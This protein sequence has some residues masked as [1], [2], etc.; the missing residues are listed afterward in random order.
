M[1]WPP[2]I[3]ETLP[4]AAD[5]WYEPTKLTRWVLNDLGHGAEWAR[6]MHVGIE[7]AA[8]VW[9][10]ISV[11]ATT[12]R[13]TGLRDLGRFGLSCEVDARLTIGERTATFRTIWHY[14][15]PEAAPRLVSAFP[16]L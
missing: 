16:K 8:E 3:G 15:A 14:V 10:A 13:V 6:V 9:E 5:C 12:G 4:R 2:E 11:Q 7:D 1:G